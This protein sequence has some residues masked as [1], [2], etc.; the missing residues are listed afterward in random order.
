MY[1]QNRCN[2]HMEGYYPTNLVR[3]RLS[4]KSV[5]HALVTEHGKEKFLKLSKPTQGA[6]LK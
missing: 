1:Y 2:V 6:N 4:C 3:K 5:L